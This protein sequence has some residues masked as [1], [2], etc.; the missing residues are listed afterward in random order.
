MRP[1]PT[2]RPDPH[3]YA[4]T[5]GVEVIY[6]PLERTNG[7]WVPEHRLI[8]LKEGM[9]E[10]KERCTLAHELAH[11][12][13]GHTESTARNEWQ[14][15]RYAATHQVDRDAFLYWWPRCR[16]VDEVAFELEV[17]RKL[18]LAFAGLVVPTAIPVLEDVA[19]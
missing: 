12:V 3:E 6:Q 1:K 4:K 5:L 16:T 14:A 11:F 15:D 9:T 2:T 18:V 7:L 8:V 17:T 10:V 19:A 13:L